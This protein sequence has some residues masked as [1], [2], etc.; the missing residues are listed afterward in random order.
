MDLTGK[1]LPLGNR[2]LDNGALEGKIIGI[3]FGEDDIVVR[4]RGVVTDVYRRTT[5]AKGF[6]CV[7]SHRHAVEVATIIFTFQGEVEGSFEL[8]ATRK[9][10]GFFCG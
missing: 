2:W 9:R 6:G 5:L 7:V 3:V 1:S 10:A 4:V 8:V